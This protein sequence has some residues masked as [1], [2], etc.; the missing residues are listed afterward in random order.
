M[1]RLAQAIIILCVLTNRAAFSASLPSCDAARRLPCP[2]TA[3]VGEYLKC[4]DQKKALFSSCKASMQNQLEAKRKAILDTIDNAA[5]EAGAEVDGELGE[6]Q[7]HLSE[8]ERINRENE[9]RFKELGQRLAQFIEDFEGEVRPRVQQF[10]E[11]YRVLSDKINA[12]SVSSKPEDRVE[13]QQIGVELEELSQE[14]SN[15]L[16][17]AGSRVM[18]LRGEIEYFSENY[19]LAMQSH[20]QFLE[21]KGYGGIAFDTSD[22]MNL[23]RRAD[24]SLIQALQALAERRQQL[25]DRIQ[26]ATTTLIEMYVNKKTKEVM[27]DARHMKSAAEFLAQ[28]NAAIKKAFVDSSLKQSGVPLYQ[29]KYQSIIEFI[30]FAAVCETQVKAVWMQEGCSFAL[31]K[32]TAAKQTLKQMPSNM[33]LSIQLAL[34]K[35]PRLGA[36]AE[37]VKGALVQKDLA[38]AS[39]LHDEL[40]KEAFR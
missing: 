22:Y 28:V 4:L 15:F 18:L 36:S 9:A 19:R 39:R 37:I 1:T 33:Q 13:L 17:V 20:K 23:A 30:Q 21:E 2:D 10:A 27:D 26:M 16:A 25:S 5:R 32:L 12:A 24:Q 6:V 38:R 11:S 3:P 14:E 7:F 31:Q 34:A 35:A 8:L 29:A 40:V